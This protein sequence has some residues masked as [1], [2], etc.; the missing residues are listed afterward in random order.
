MEW[1]NGN[2]PITFPGL[3]LELDPA[4]GFR[5]GS[6]YTPQRSSQHCLQ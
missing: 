2:S 3:G 1:I 6:F 5:I 4:V